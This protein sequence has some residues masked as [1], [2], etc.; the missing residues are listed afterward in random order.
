MSEI[1]NTKENM[2]PQTKSGKKAKKKGGFKEFVK[3][4]K[5]R[6]N[7]AIHRNGCYS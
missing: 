3:S 6:F 4:R 2:T 7:A 5:A 1:K